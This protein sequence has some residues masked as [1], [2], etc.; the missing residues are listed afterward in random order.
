MRIRKQVWL[1][2]LLGMLLGPVGLLYSSVLG[3]AIMLVVFT[4]LTMLLGPAGYLL[5]AA[6]C[7]VYGWIACS[8]YNDTFDDE[9]RRAHSLGAQWTRTNT[10]EEI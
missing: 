8:V 7:G 4:L 5:G 1:G 10:K 9:I 3:A 6:M 2:T